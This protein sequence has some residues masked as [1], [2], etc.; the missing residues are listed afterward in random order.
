MTRCAHK[1]ITETHGLLKSQNAKTL[2]GIYLT[3]RIRE[4]M[5]AVMTEF[6]KID[7]GYKQQG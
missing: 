6:A 4:T 5:A 2:C 1:K 7:Q 3:E